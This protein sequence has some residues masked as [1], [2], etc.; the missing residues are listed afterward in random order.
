MNGGS[1]WIASPLRVSVDIQTPFADDLTFEGDLTDY[2]Q[3]AAWALAIQIAGG[4]FH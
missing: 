1:A 3:L 2:L 4:T